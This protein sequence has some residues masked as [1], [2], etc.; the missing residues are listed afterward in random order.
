MSASLEQAQAQAL[1]S[2]AQELGKISSELTQIKE[3]LRQLLPQ[4]PGAP[5]R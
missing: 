5:R 1:V 2:I 3:I 4:I